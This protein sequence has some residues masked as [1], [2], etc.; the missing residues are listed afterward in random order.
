MIFYRCTEN[1]CNAAFTTKQCLQF[2]YKKVHGYTGDTMPKIERCI[3]YTFDSY[4]GGM[5]PDPIRAKGSVMN[6]PDDRQNPNDEMSP[7]QAHQLSNADHLGP[8]DDEPMSPI[9]SNA[10]TPTRPPELLLAAAVSKLPPAATLHGYVAKYA[11]AASRLVSKGSKKWLGD[12]L[13][14]Y[15]REVEGHTPS[16]PRDI[17]EFEERLDGEILHRRKEKLEDENEDDRVFRRGSNASLLVEAALNVA[18]NTLKSEG[19]QV[20]PHDRLLGYATNSNRYSPPP[21]VTSS[22]HLLPHD[23]A[24]TTHI[25]YTAATDDERGHLEYTL[26]REYDPRDLPEVMVVHDGIPSRDL[27]DSLTHELHENLHTTLDHLTPASVSDSSLT[28][29]QDSNVEHAHNLSLAKSDELAPAT[30][31]DPDTSLSTTGTLEPTLH[32]LDQ[33]PV[34]HGMPVTISSSL[35]V[36][37]DMTYKHYRIVPETTVAGLSHDHLLA[38]TPLEDTER[39]MGLETTI[40]STSGGTPL[41]PPHDHLTDQIPLPELQPHDFR[42]LPALRSPEPPRSPYLSP[43]PT[44]ETLRSYLI[45]A[46]GLRSP[47]TVEQGID[48]S[49]TNLLLR[50]ADIAELSHRYQT[51]AGHQVVRT[52]VYELERSVSHSMDLTVPRSSA[53]TSTVYVTSPD[54]RHSLDLTLPRHDPDQDQEHEL[55]RAQSP[56]QHTRAASPSLQPSPH[57]LSPHNQLSPH[58]QL[59][60]YSQVSPSTQLSPHP[61]M[62]P[63]PHIGM[64]D[65]GNSSSPEVNLIRQN[66]DGQSPSP[67]TSTS[68]SLSHPLPPI[69]RIVSSSPHSGF[70]SSRQL[71][72]L[73]RQDSPTQLPTHIYTE[74]FVTTGSGGNL[75]SMVPL[76]PVSMSNKDR[77]SPYLQYP[78][79]PYPRQDI[80]S[81]PPSTY[82][83]QY[84]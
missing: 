7:S 51:E 60:P 81:P 44:P 75:Q 23:V 32:V 1:G 35:A 29:Q 25:K 11:A 27:N 50:P 36:G 41:S 46:E 3:P 15:E 54:I 66:I 63:L 33:L 70:Y 72:P 40:T 38:A 49:R 16:T 67:A 68:I 52:S 24:L 57:Q 78:S 53:V 71:I 83:Y 84:Y 9:H 77:S 65:R 13:D 21:S 43:S 20:G 62:S 37:I 19:R 18:E 2:H 55:V 26:E 4:S 47:F 73:S 17:Y 79:S 6:D 10:E 59:P 39:S 56:F 22:D 30:P 14:S 45:P 31:A 28:P 8:P 58:T 12:S 34:T 76:T 42:G 5:V 64:L 82:H 69:S 61:Q 74:S 48:M 80:A